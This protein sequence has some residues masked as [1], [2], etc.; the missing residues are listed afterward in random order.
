MPLRDLTPQ[1]RTRLFRMERLV[2]LFVTVAA[3]L[4]IAGFLFYLYHTAERRGWFVPR[5]PYFTFVAT[6]DGL[7]IGDP[8]LL[9]GFKVGEITEIEAQPP[10]SYYA[11]FVGFY[12][13][14]PY[15]GYVWTDSKVRIAGG[16]LLGGRLLELTKGVD[17][18]PTVYE[19]D[20]RVHE[21]LVK[22]EK[23]PIENAPKGV[24]IEPLEEPTLAERAQALL[25]VLEKQ[26][27]VIVEQIETVLASTESATTSA[28]GLADDAQLAVADARPILANL[29][30]ITRQLRNPD[31]S[32]GAWLLTP[33]LREGLEETLTVLNRDLESLNDTLTNVAGMTGSLRGQVESNDYILDELSSLITETDDLVRGLKR[34]WLL[35][36]AF[37]LPPAPAPEA[38]EA[39]LLAPPAAATP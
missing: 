6:A 17:G 36:S 18:Q 37:T 16:D 39:P 27:P 14:R 12:V 8:I 11:V 24:F 2:G 26:L 29:E 20:G 32:L 34:H 3:A 22:G 10:D 31:G 7:N 1:L 38:I 15:Y 23:V 33:E 30:T 28:A 4:V 19:E 13:R 9:M 5:S 35:E 25:E 21:V